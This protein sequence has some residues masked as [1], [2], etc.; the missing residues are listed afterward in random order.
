MAD[1]GAVCRLGGRWPDFAMADGGAVCRGAV[2]RVVVQ[3][4]VSQPA[5]HP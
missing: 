4:P 5:T 1:G 2:C 3:Q